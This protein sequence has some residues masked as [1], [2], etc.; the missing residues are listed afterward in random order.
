M[1]PDLESLPKLK[2]DVECD[3]SYCGGK[4]RPGTGIHKRGRGTQKTPVF[5]MVER[6]GNIHRRVVADVTGNTL[7]DAIREHVDPQS[8]I[9]TDEFLSYKGIGKHF[10]GGHEV[11]CH[12]KGEYARKDG[13]IHTNTAE[14]SFAIL[15]RGLIGIFHA[16][17]KQHLHRYVSEFDFRWNTRRMNDG[18]RVALAIKGAIGKRLVYE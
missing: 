2:G 14:A 11:I 9:L 8:R 7:K 12:G 17:S 4:P 6:G 15:K 18:D 13:D 1:T 3:E 5:A 10:S 16:V